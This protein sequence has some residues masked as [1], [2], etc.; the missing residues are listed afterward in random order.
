MK[1]IRKAIYNDVEV[2]SKE[3]LITPEILNKL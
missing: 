1:I 2:Q 3:L